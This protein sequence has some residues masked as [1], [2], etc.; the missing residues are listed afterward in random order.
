M[1]ALATDL[2]RAFHQ[3]PLSR[4]STKY[5][6]VV[7][8][9]RGVQV[10]ARSAVSMPGSETALK[11]PMCLVLVHLLEKRIIARI[12]DDLYCIENSPHKLPQ[13]WRKELQALMHKYNLRLSP[14][15]TIINPHSTTVVG[16]VLNLLSTC[17]PRRVLRARHGSSNQ[18]IYRFIHSHM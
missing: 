5:S 3:I 2:T 10:Y 1:E 6:R 11:Q 8:P 12:V 9:F 13:N 14:S 16:W 17:S 15:K 4:D 7:T 18:I